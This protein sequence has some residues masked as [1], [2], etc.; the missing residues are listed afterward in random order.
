MCA[1]SRVG[2][3][4]LGAS[5]VSYVYVYN[6]IAAMN[7]GIVPDGKENMGAQGE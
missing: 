4:C 2:N 6:T 3:E 1:W 7:S 5:R